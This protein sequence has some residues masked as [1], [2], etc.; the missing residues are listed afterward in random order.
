MPNDV[1]WLDF[2]TDPDDVHSLAETIELMLIARPERRLALAEL[3]ARFPAGNQPSDAEMML[4]FGEIE[5]RSNSMGDLYPFTKD[6]RGV[7]FDTAKPWELYAF[8]LLL[9]FQGTHLRV[10]KNWPRSDELFDR[11]ALDAV[12]SKVGA[13][14]SGLLFG[15]PPRDGRPKDFRDAVRWVS[16]KLGVDLRTAYEKLPDHFKDGGVDI[17]AWA[18][19]NDQRTGFPIYLVQNTVQFNYV[20]KP[21]DVS[22][23]RWRDWI[24]LGATPLVGFVIPFFVPSSHRWWDEVAAEVSLFLHR[25][26]IMEALQGQDPTK[27]GYWEEIRTFVAVELDALESK[28]PRGSVKSMDVRKLKKRA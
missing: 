10:E 20:K 8:L 5:R 25:P 18:P 2:Q 14:A 3:R 24:D 28:T 11:V 6:G 7:A 21:R 4:A 26:R 9:S 12:L 15:S 19:F 16:Q 22:P 1:S 27:W 17:I 13:G 23:S